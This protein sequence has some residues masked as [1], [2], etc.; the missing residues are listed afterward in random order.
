MFKFINNLK[1]NTRIA[2][3]SS[4]P[5]VGLAIIGGSIFTAKN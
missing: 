4:A 5:L 2:L 1:I 3:L